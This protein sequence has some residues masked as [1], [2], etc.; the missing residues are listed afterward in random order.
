[1]RR[2]NKR[3]HFL[4]GRQN[5]QTNQPGAQTQISADIAEPERDPPYETIPYE[6]SHLGQTTGG[7]S[8]SE[9]ESD[10]TEVYA[11]TAEVHTETDSVFFSEPCEDVSVSQAEPLQSDPDTCTRNGDCLNPMDSVIYDTRYEPS[12]SPN[13]SSRMNTNPQGRHEDVINTACVDTATQNDADTLKNEGS[14]I[15]DTGYEASDD[16]EDNMSG[17]H[18][19]TAV[20]DGAEN[21]S[22]E[23]FENSDDSLRPPSPKIYDTENKSSGAVEYEN[24]GFVPDTST[25]IYEFTPGGYEELRRPESDT[26]ESPG[27]DED[28][29]SPEKPITCETAN[30]K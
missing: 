28:P 23:S 21:E 2:Q 22:A 24:G 5:T 19:D 3:A 15:Y 12:A 29:P 18:E 10:D 8:E 4:F 27:N 1:M 25:G 9:S 14:I 6:M 16:T 11:D 17:I 30:D 20:N 26:K 7:H 13:P